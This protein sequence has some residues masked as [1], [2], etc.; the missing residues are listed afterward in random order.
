[1]NRKNLRNKIRKL[2]I[3]SRLLSESARAIDD[4]PDHG[5]IMI[6][7][8]RNGGYDISYAYEDPKN[9]GKYMASKYT[10]SSGFYGKIV[11]QSPNKDND[12]R[13][14][15]SGAW[16]VS[17]A[18]AADGWGPLLYDVAIE[19]ATLHGNGLISDRSS[20]SEDAAKVWDYYLNNR[21]D[22]NHHQLD[23]LYDEL[24]P[25]IEEDNCKQGITR[26]Q[27]RRGYPWHESSLSKRYTKPP[28]VI[29]KLHSVGKLIILE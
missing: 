16:E 27:G 10:T 24:T 29:N 12:Y 19:Y 9:S 17:W 11:I 23:N 1:M 18:R 14:P 28:S 26:H 20:V 15:C 3:E 4:F 8:M 21:T 6:K 13:G 5:L 22:V 2:I 25:D 7:P